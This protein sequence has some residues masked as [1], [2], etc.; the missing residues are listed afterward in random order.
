MNQDVRRELQALKRAAGGG[1]EN[2]VFI[3]SKTG[4]LA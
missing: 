3:S 4:Y 1:G 2:L